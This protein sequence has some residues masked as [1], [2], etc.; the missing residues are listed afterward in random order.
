MQPIIDYG[1]CVWGHSK[2]K[3]AESVQNRAMHFFLGVPCKT[4]TTTVIEE[5]GWTASRV[6]LW[7]CSSRQW[8]YYSNMEDDRLNKHVFKWVVNSKSK[9]C[10]SNFIK[11][12]R[13]FDLDY[14]T[15]VQL[16]E[17]KHQV[18]QYVRNVLQEDY[19]QNI[20]ISI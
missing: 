9:N 7:T 18:T 5:M 13:H 12:F 4:P 17:Y 11:K 15:D 8:C 20:W 14:V 10:E 19:I 16:P 2:Y 3:Y 1:S 6:R